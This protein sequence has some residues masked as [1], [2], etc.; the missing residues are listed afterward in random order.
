MSQSNIPPITPEDAMQ[1]LQRLRASIDN[2]DAILLH[3]LAERFKV[4]HAVGVLKAK[5]DLPPAD[6]AREQK[7]IERVRHL[8]S[9]SG[10]DPA[11]AARCLNFIVVEVIRH[12]EQLREEDPKNKTK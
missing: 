4:T 7:Q 9:I 6:K 1:Q 8:A 5:N 11:C 3:T 2:L 10:L 12:H